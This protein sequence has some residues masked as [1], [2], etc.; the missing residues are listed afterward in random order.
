MAKLFISLEANELRTHLNEQIGFLHR[1]G[2]LYDAG[3]WSEAKRLATHATILAFDSGVKSKNLSLIS[4]LGLREDLRILST[5]DRM[6][7]G[8]I[9][10]APEMRLCGFRARLRT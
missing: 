8:L 9:N 6:Y 3:H 5:A 10:Y 7:P 1:S 4:L 2:E